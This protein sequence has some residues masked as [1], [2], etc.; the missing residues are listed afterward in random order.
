MV[1]LDKL[2][3]N[4]LTRRYNRGGK[5]VLA[6]DTLTPEQKMW[7]LRALEYIYQVWHNEASATHVQGDEDGAVI[8]DNQRRALAEIR[9]H[10]VKLDPAAE[11]NVHNST[12]LRRPDGSPWP[13]VSHSRRER[14]RKSMQITIVF[15]AAAIGMILF[16][17]FT[18]G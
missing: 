15:A 6:D 2:A 17:L 1:D 18:E 9:A 7:V 16:T 8:L 13:E 3:P 10:I 12:V 4:E 11:P 14:H 5:S